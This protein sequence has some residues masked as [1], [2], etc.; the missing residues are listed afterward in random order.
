M[1]AVGLFVD[2][3]TIENYT[4]GR[5]GLFKGGG[6]YLLGVQILAVVS[7]TIWSATVTF[8]LLKVE[9]FPSLSNYALPVTFHAN[10]NMCF[11]LL[12]MNIKIPA[13]SNLNSVQIA[14]VLAV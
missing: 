1:I 4:S 6:L 8:L 2:E 12:V 3:D 7:I 9:W 14:N 10:E 11:F 5:K 13:Y